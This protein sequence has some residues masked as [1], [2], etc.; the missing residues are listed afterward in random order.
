MFAEL[1]RMFIFAN[2]SKTS[3]PNFQAMSTWREK[4][5]SRFHLFSTYQ[6]Y[7]QIFDREWRFRF[8]NTW[9]LRL[10]GH[11]TFWRKILRF[12][13]HR[14][15]LLF[16]KV[17]CYSIQYTPRMCNPAANAGLHTSLRVLKSGEALKN[18]VTSVVITW[19]A[20]SSHIPFAVAPASFRRTS[21][22]M[23]TGAS[24]TITWRS[25]SF[26]ACGF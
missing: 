6:G 21:P 1:D 25:R 18:P 23:G 8:E 3:D 9:G 26:A 10:S 7:N 16:Q 2:V 13:L 14:L 19:A 11:M 17:S 12:S 5:S 22:K 15:H 24:Y 20:S 4:E